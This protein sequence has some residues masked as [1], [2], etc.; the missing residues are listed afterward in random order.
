MKINIRLIPVLAGILALVSCGPSPEPAAD[1]APQG[2]TADTSAARPPR[3]DLNLDERGRG[4][5][6]YD[7]VAY[8]E[9][10]QAVPG[11]EDIYVSWDGATYLFADETHRTAFLE[12]PTR[13]VPHH[14]GFCTFGIVL[15]KKFDGDPEVWMIRDDRLHVFLNRDVQS[16]FLGDEDANFAR[17]VANWPQIRKK[18]A[19]Q[20]EE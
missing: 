9:D 2:T 1:L 16:K 10:G 6:G 3:P 7:P 19:Q 14:G 8:F 13:Y 20:L 11:H 15:G 17:V 5:R 12:Q 18:T 4:L